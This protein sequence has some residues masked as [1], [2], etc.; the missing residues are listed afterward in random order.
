M[1]VEKQIAKRRNR[2]G[3]RIGNRVRRSAHGR[4]RLS[5]YRSNK[6]IYAQI[7]DDALGQTLAMSVALELALT[8]GPT[9]AL[10][11]TLGAEWLLAAG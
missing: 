5:V 6:H 9:L 1:K 8:L 7:I 10:T 3:L 11:L 2:R 4:P